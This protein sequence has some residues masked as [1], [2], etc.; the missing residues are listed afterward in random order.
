MEHRPIPFCTLNW[1]KK[2][3]RS[4][5]RTIILNATTTT[6]TGFKPYSEMYR[7]SDGKG[8]MLS[9]KKFALNKRCPE[10]LYADR[11][12]KFQPRKAWF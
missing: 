12:F 1:R 11:N 5:E 7:Q 9:D 2:S 4:F 3:R 10:N 6:A 8:T